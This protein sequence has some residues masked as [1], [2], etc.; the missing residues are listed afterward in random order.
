MIEKHVPRH[1]PVSIDMNP[2]LGLSA[3][4]SPPRHVNHQY[5]CNP[6]TQCELDIGYGMLVRESWIKTWI[7]AVIV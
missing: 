4:S 7:F 1:G 6:L 3:P 5:F 2:L